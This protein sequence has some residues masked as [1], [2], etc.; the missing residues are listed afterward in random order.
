MMIR[1]VDVDQFDPNVNT[2]VEHQH[3]TH[4]QI[5]RRTFLLLGTGLVDQ[6]YKISWEVNILC[7]AI[8]WSGREKS[9]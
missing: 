9:M 6:D 8:L 1:G 4:S 2:P 3:L 7:Q 5:T